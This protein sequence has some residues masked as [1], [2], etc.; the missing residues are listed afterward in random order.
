MEKI[1]I[2]QV[3]QANSEHGYS[4]FSPETMRFFSSKVSRS[5]YKIGNK[6]YFITSEQNK[7]T[8]DNPRKWTIRCGDLTTGIV[9]TVSEFQEFNSHREAKKQLKQ[10]LRGNER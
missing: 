10:I 1:D 7:L 9:H 8:G 2:E 4:Y 5:A 3:K 6:A